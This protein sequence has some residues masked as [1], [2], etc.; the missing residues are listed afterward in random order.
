[1]Y[2]K[3]MTTVY[4]ITVGKQ[5]DVMTLM[6]FLDYLP[7]QTLCREVGHGGR[8]THPWHSWLMKIVHLRRNLADTIWMNAWEKRIQILEEWTVSLSE[9]VK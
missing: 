1:M 7:T 4:C 6:T 5:L 2:Q 3:Q 8:V 9:S